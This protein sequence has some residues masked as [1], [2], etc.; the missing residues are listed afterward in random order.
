MLT[1]VIKNTIAQG[2]MLLVVFILFMADG[3]KKQNH[4]NRCTRT[5]EGRKTRHFS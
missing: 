1:P 4:E 2:L 3:K 5:V